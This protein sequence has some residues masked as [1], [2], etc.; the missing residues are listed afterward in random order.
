MCETY[1]T[2]SPY[3]SHSGSNPDHSN[4]RPLLLKLHSPKRFGEEV[5]KLVLCA[6]VVGFDA[7]ILQAAP[8]EVILHPNVLDALT[9]D[10]VPRQGQSG[11]AIHPKL[12]CFGIS[13]RRSPTS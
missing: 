5:S 2:F 9:E 3:V 10:K 6:N 4:P 7:P 11:L 1:L 12:Y 13:A 8:Y